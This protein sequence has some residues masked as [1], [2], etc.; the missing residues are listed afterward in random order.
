ML[1][2]WDAA[3]S[4]LPF[5]PPQLGSAGSD[6]A[7]VPPTLLTARPWPAGRSALPPPRLS[8]QQ[9]APSTR[10]APCAPP[11]WPRGCSPIRPLG[12]SCRPRTAPAPC[13]RGHFLPAQLGGTRLRGGG[14][15]D[16]KGPPHGVSL[17][18]PAVPTDYPAAV[19]PNK[20]GRRLCVSGRQPRWAEPGNPSPTPPGCEEAPR[21]RPLGEEERLSPHPGEAA[22]LPGAG[23]APWR[24][25]GQ[26]SG[27]SAQKSGLPGVSAAPSSFPQGWSLPSSCWVRGPPVLSSGR[28]TI[29]SFLQFR[30]FC[31]LT[32]S[33]L[34]GTDA[35]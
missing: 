17:A 22:R 30:Y 8:G 31:G 21:P 1:G 2:P 10:G 23:R 35:R 9:R 27:R 11:S 26:R 15:S 5:P 33:P 19:Q 12:G 4:P 18:P 3:P 25:S 14:G 29:L 16:S 28:W 6:K 24:E 13:S 20:P 32:E 34:Q 7:A